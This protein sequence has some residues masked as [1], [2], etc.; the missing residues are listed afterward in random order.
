MGELLRGG[1]EGTMDDGR[2]I[3]VLLSYLWGARMA[4]MV[5][6]AESAAALLQA[7]EGLCSL[8]VW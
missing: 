8:G 5:R 1:G 3:A 2:R 4:A 7:K 6:E